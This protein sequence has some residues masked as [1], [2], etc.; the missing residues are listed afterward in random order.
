[1]TDTLGAALYGLLTTV[2]AEEE[3]PTFDVYVAGDAPAKAPLPF[4][5]YQ[6]SAA[7]A[8]AMTTSAQMGMRRVQ[9]NVYATDSEL[10]E[11]IADRVEAAMIDLEAA[12]SSGATTLTG[13]F[14]RA[15]GSYRVTDYPGL[16]DDGTRAFRVILTF[17][18][19]EQL[20]M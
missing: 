18:Q 10:A 9:I 7:R 16:R 1:M 11:D 15:E 2:A 14:E 5:T 12:G 19:R 6:R 17:E 13:G 20:A 8:A 4:V 3:Q